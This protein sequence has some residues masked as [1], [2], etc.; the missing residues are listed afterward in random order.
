[1]RALHTLALVLGIGLFAALVAHVGPARLWHDASVLG[2]G[3]AWVIAIEGLADFLHTWAW[4]RCFS[5]FHRPGALRLWWPHLAVAAIN[6]VTPTATLGG[7]VVWSF[8]QEILTP[9]FYHY[10]WP[11]QTNQGEHLP[12]GA[13]WLTMRVDGKD[14]YNLVFGENP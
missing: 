12:P 4:Q 8:S 1:M 6:F 13:Y 10:H 14:L 7:E 2:W 9:G 3:V 5:P 11:G